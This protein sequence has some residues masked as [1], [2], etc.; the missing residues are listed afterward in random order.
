MNMNYKL[1][2]YAIDF[3][4]FLI[5]ELDRNMEKVKAIILFGSVARGEANA[6]SDVDIFVDTID[7][8]IE[9]RVKKI[10]KEFYQSRKCTEYWKLLG[11]HSEIKCMVGNLPKWKSLERSII[12]SGI[13]LYDK[14]QGKYD[15]TPYALF[16]VSVKKKRH[17]S[18]KI[19]RKLYGYTQKV[20]KK[21]YRSKGLVEEYGGRKITK[22]IILIP[23]GKSQHLIDFLKTKRVQY[24][25]IEFLTDAKI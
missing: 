22:G 23:M 21:T 3:A 17:E 12:S 9:E 1:I 24:Q 10:V 6:Q 11:V 13:T 16:M 8:S 19:W 5:Q 20:G 7:N 15:T 2:S 18:V 25:L 4:S 14:Y